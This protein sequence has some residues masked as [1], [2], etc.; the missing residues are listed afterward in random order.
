MFRVWESAYEEVQLGSPFRV[1]EPVSLR[2]ILNFINGF[3]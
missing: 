1:V 2:A 3:F